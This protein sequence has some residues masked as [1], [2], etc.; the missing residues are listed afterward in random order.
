MSLNF[1]ESWTQAGMKIADKA[2]ERHGGWKAWENLSSIKIRP[3]NL[4]GM[5]PTIKGYGKSFYRPK[6]IEIFP[7]EQRVLFREF[8]HAGNVGEYL[9]GD[10]KL[11]KDYQL[12]DLLTDN[13]HAR[14][15]FLA[16][17]KTDFGVTP[18]VYIFLGMLGRLTSAFRSSFP[19]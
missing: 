7:K 15:H 2:I 8:P 19:L 6:V 11:F 13:Q 4:S 10:V 16:L 5:V 9:H 3:L 14:L 18:I 17:R 12:C 1:N